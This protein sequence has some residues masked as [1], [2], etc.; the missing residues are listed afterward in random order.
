MYVTDKA[1]YNWSVN[2]VI[3]NMRH[4]LVENASYF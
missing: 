3:A 2:S 1:I 4:S